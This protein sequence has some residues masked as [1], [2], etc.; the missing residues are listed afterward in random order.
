METLLDQGKPAETVGEPFQCF[1][2]F[3]GN[4]IFG[5][6]VTHVREVIEFEK[7]FSIPRTPD[8][9]TGVINLRGEV[10]PVID[11][12]ARLYSRKS[13]PG[14]LTCIVIAEIV[15]DGEKVKMGLLVDSIR[16]VT[17]IS[18]ENLCAAP[19]FGAKIRSEF[20]SGIGKDTGKFII[21]LNVDTLLNIGELSDFGTVPNNRRNNI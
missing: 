1:T 16:A 10:V 5:I 17:D 21:I 11:L 6:G 3:V 19:E 13:I 14:K 7:V 12:S 4:E 2:F 20:I 9:I 8:N 18:E 15:H